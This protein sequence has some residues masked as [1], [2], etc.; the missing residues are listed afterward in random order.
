MDKKEHK[1]KKKKTI[2]S[3]LLIIAIFA[4]LYSGYKILLWLEDNK[5]SKQ[6]AEEVTNAVA[7]IENEKKEDIKYE[8]DFKR[9]K[10]KNNETVAWV[11]VNGT[12]VEYP[13]VKTTNND[14]YLNH[15]FDKSNN[16][17][18]WVFMDYKNKLDGTDKNI[19]IYGHNRRD[20]SM[21]GTLKNVLTEQWCNDKENY[22]IPFA[23]ENKDYKYQIFSAYSI[24]AEDYYI[25]TSFLNDNEFEQFLN[26]IKREK[27]KRF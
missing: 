10:E 17:A 15:S 20:G 25:T 6:I 16:G 2:S 11:K 13:V 4:M 8:I 23:V 26:N 1:Y 27:Y 19:V 5:K 3:I 18:G 24:E 22:I 12:D 7:V 21:F 14:Y 9:L